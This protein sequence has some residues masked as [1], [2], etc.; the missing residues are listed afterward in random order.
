MS[1]DLGLKPKNGKISE[2]EFKKYFSSRQN[3]KMKGSRAWYENDLTGVYFYFEFFRE[4]AED[5]EQYPI[6]FNLNY[7][8]PTFFINEAEPEVSSFID[9]FSLVVNDY[10]TKGM[11]KGNYDKKKLHSGWKHGNELAYKHI[12]KDDPKTKTYTLT[13]ENLKYIWE[14]NYNRETTQKYVTN[15][16]F[17]PKIMALE[18]K[19]KTVSAS[20]WPDDAIPLL[21]PKVDII[22]FGR[23]EFAPKKLFQKRVEDMAIGQFSD[24]EPVFEKYREKIVRGGYYIYY[25]SVPG[26][27]SQKIKSL[28]PYIKSDVVKLAFDVVLDAELINKYS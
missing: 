11:G 16:V 18:Y 19:G 13:T 24:F 28:P 7:F 15:K 14:W 22:V 12:L 27:L 8:R 2:A 9:Y 6:L 10:Q 1:Y 25:D 21:L 26:P 3:Y 17:V 5:E 23:I 4:N 20:I